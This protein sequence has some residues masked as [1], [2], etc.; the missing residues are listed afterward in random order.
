MRLPSDVHDRINDAAPVGLW[1]LDTS[2]HTVSYNPRTLELLGRDDAALRSVP[3]VELVHPSARDEFRA[4][5]E[6]LAGGDEH[7]PETE[8]LFV[9][10][11]GSTTW[12]LVSARLVEHH[13]AG[14]M[15]VQWLHEM[16]RR[17]ELH[18]EVLYQR[19]ELAA[20][21]QL[22]RIASW[23]LNLST[24]VVSWSDAMYDLLGWDR[25]REPMTLEEFSE[26]VVP[27]DRHLLDAAIAEVYD[28][29]QLEY[30]LRVLR[31]DGKVIW[32]RCRGA[33][34]RDRDGQMKTL[35]A[36]THDVTQQKETELELL[37]AVGL[38]HFLRSLTSDAN[39]SMTVA[40]AL[41]RMF[42]RSLELDP[43]IRMVTFLPVIDESG[44]IE[45][46]AHY[47]G[48]DYTGPAAGHDLPT[49]RELRCAYRVLETREIQ[50]IEF[51][52][53]GTVEMGHASAYLG[54][55]FVVVVI[56]V[57]NT[58]TS[59]AAR[60]ALLETVSVQLIRVT[61]REQ[62]NKEL[63]AA[64]DAALE[65]SRHKSAFLAT[66]S[67]EIRTPLNGVIGLNDLLLRTELD[68]N[69]RRITEGVQA[70]GRTL[71]AVINDV[72]DFSKIEAGRLELESV[73]FDLRDVIDR[74]AS[75][76]GER[77]YEKGIEL[78]VSVRPD[79][80][81][82]L[83]G[84]PTRLSQILT[85]LVSNAVKFTSEGEVIVL[86]D[87][88]PPEDDTAT[89]DDVLLRIEVSDTGTGVATD[90]QGDLFDAFSQAEMSTTREYGGTG[91]GLAICR[92]LVSAI[93]GEIGVNSEIDK[94]ST[95]W[96]TGHFLIGEPVVATDRS[97][98]RAHVLVGRRAL[99]VDDNASNR[100]ILT[101]LLQ[102]WQIEVAQAAGAV[103][104]VGKVRAA[105]SNGE[106][107][108]LVLLDLVMP[109]HD[110]LELASMITGATD[111]PWPTLLLLSSAQ[112]VDKD[113]LESAGIA[114]SLT[115]PVGRSA[116][117]DGLV[118]SLAD[119]HGVEEVT[120]QPAG[121]VA[122][123][124]GQHVLLVE[125]NEINQM[126]AT[127]VLA[128][129]GYTVEVARDGVEAVEMAAR[130]SYD[131]ILMD[132]Q[133]PR[134]NGYEATRAIRAQEPDGRRVA[135]IAMTAAAVEGERE[136]CLE[137][138][139]D[140]F[141]TKPLEPE[142]LAATLRSWLPEPPSKGVG[143]TERVLDPSRLE[144]LRALGPKAVAII[145]RSVATFIA[146]AD[147]QVADMRVT[148]LADDATGLR[149]AA[150]SL[151][152]SAG[153][154]GA[155]LVADICGLLED[156]ADT[157]TTHGADGH[158]R[159]LEAALPATLAA[160]AAQGPA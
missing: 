128:M 139:M 158:L 32:L 67:H 146:Q 119:L 64:R 43:N 149:S 160:L 137:S 96:F 148:V 34:R 106:P 150:H 153:N 62:T 25:S 91:L 30:E 131:A 89:T 37:E 55:V 86:C 116:L 49:G 10:P 114:V 84:D 40:A 12:L 58:H 157:G 4:H 138:G 14:P 24:G 74:S 54:E 101:E 38:S 141:L 133:M 129:L 72:L 26:H 115:K 66:M 22:A 36:T 78:A 73:D 35:L 61:E 15:V 28:T 126:V 121:E 118:D 7:V 90:R 16:T 39:D 75:L 6:A 93:G 76:L 136:R 103:E 31:D 85:N 108:D 83:R 140:A 88:L 56:T 65:A 44:E 152:G 8:R 102:E 23:R 113:R 60:E 107:F 124:R 41:D 46:V 87:V 100:R 145:D 20:A 57:E 33:V 42:Q 47:P 21:Q 68:G 147:Q 79:V 71:L 5:L 18:Q 130:T 110:G 159:E 134:M 80:P 135:I 94:G 69:Q 156:L 104:A 45:L 17:E 63:S 3:A 1:V 120:R 142:R 2:G 59:N 53:D 52:E 151:R 50:I 132:V 77:A 19:E 111:E 82:F 112:N 143:D 123:S 144:S 105:A 117:F 27:E 154:L 109:R 98:D 70:A 11:D 155:V 99:V 92:Q 13:A 81:Q 48:R 51:D 95:F 125:D 97:I 9:R 122:E 29:G 127:G